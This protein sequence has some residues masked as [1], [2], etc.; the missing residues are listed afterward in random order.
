MPSWN[1]HRHGKIKKR[2]QQNWWWHERSDVLSC[3][4]SLRTES[5]IQRGREDRLWGELQMEPT[6]S[7]LHEEEIQGCRQWFGNY[8][9][10]NIIICIWDSYNH[11]YDPLPKRPGLILIYP[12][13]KPL[14]DLKLFNSNTKENV[15]KLLVNHQYLVVSKQRTVLCF[16]FSC[17]LFSYE[18]KEN[19]NDVDAFLLH[20]LLWSPDTH[21]NHARLPFIDFSSAL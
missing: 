17:S 6:N 12:Y 11:K 14:W 5:T 8:I 13:W 19:T 21:D 16:S 18:Q 7:T 1:L 15:M 2:I 9:P 20:S 3:V 4:Y 10:L